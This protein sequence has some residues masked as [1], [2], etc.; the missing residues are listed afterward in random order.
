MLARRPSRIGVG[1]LAEE[2]SASVA[3]F[4]RAF[5]EIVYFRACE[6]SGRRPLSCLLAP[7]SV[8][9][10]FVSELLA[11]LVAPFDRLLCSHGT[12]PCSWVQE[13]D[14]VG[15]RAA[16]TDEAGV[17]AWNSHHA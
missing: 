3:A 11:S 12:L 14:R 1:V 5:G 7:A 6:R 17:A 4:P 10:W 15:A 16:R 13:S 9:S 8:R 2:S